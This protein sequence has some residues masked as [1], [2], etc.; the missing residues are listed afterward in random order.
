[1]IDRD[2]TGGARNPLDMDAGDIEDWI[3][4]LEDLS[5]SGPE[6]DTLSVTSTPKPSLRPFFAS[7]RSLL[8]PPLDP[9]SYGHRNVNVFPSTDGTIFPPATRSV[10]AGGGRLERHHS[11][12]SSRKAGDSDST[13]GESMLTDPEQSDTPGSIPPT[14]QSIQLAIQPDDNKSKVGNQIILFFNFI[15]SF[16]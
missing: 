3:D 15:G 9:L 7:S 6:M 14:V 1:M 16:F 2:R 5:D 13:H 4:Q 10:M 12:E 11:D 8:A